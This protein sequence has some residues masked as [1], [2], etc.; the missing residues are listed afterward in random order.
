MTPLQ[1]ILAHV[2]LNK[3]D[4]EEKIEEEEEE[5]EESRVTR[6]GVNNSDDG[7]ESE[8]DQ[9]H[10]QS[11]TS[12]GECKGQEQKSNCRIKSEG[13]GRIKE[14]TG[15][16]KGQHRHKDTDKHKD[17]N[18][19]AAS[20]CS[21]P[22]WQAE[23]P[24]THCNFCATPFTRMLCRKHHCRRCGLVVCNGCS[25]SRISLAATDRVA[26]PSSSRRGS[27]TAATTTGSTG[28]SGDD[29]G[30]AALVRVCDTC[31]NLM[32]LTFR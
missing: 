5:D 23:G 6:E 2:N 3:S 1:A 19:K 26:P 12:Q 7:L 9:K 10:R 28:G 24:V 27:A 17:R 21:S 29:G 22:R 14:R 32:H 4:E 31:V 11:S 30:D 13:G 20:K 25:S 15:V 18:D 8:Q 16:A